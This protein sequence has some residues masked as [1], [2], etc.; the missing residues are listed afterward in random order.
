MED[1]SKPYNLGNGTY[2][3]T[4]AIIEPND[5]GPEPNDSPMMQITISR[6]DGTKTVEIC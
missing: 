6:P 3:E 5:H 4:G 1:Y 2:P